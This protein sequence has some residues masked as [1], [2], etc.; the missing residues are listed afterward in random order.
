M[1]IYLYGSEGR[2]CIG[3]STNWVAGEADVIWP[4]PESCPMPTQKGS[5]DAGNA[6]I[7]EQLYRHRTVDTA[8][9]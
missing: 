3:D 6:V 7:R 4:L 2:R 1:L 5:E 8:A 9:R